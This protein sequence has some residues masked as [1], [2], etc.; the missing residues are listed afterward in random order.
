MTLPQFY[1]LYTTQ[2]NSLNRIFVRHVRFIVTYFKSLIKCN[3]RKILKATRA[4]T[5]RVKEGANQSR[6]HLNAGPVDFLFRSTRKK[7][8]ERIRPCPLIRN[9]GQKCLIRHVYFIYQLTYSISCKNLHIKY[10]SK[11]YLT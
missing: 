5:V 4:I 3:K 6:P 1:N 10:F 8:N 9:V 7:K 11:F 2:F